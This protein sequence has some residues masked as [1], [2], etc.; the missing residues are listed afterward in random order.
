LATGDIFGGKPIR[1]SDIPESIKQGVDAF[2][3]LS[4]ALHDYI[5]S[6]TTPHGPTPIQELKTIWTFHQGG[7]AMDMPRSDPRFRDFPGRI[8]IPK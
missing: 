7:R 3:P 4:L 1:T 5:S 2:D 6:G 8:G